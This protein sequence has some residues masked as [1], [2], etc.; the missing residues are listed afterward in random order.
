MTPEIEEQ[1]ARLKPEEAGEMIGP[2]KLREQIGEGGFG[3]ASPGSRQAK[4]SRPPR[5]PAN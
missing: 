5:V 2:Y 1:L 3:T 4:A